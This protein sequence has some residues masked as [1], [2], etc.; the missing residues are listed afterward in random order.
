MEGMH[1][2]N[3]NENNK[4]LQLLEIDSQLK[5]LSKMKDL[6]FEA[7]VIQNKLNEL[8]EDNLLNTNP[9]SFEIES[10]EKDWEEK[11]NNL[12][13]LKVDKP[14]LETLESIELEIA[15]LKELKITL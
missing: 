1:S 10:L 14:G 6:W 5:I 4:K 2:L 8:K 11:I 13:L 7:R 9:P 12:N 3:T 15:R